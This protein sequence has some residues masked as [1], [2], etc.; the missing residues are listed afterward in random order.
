MKTNEFRVKEVSELKSHLSNLRRE[1]FKIKLVK[2]SG[3]LVKTHQFRE[4]RRDIARIETILRE[5]EGSS[6]E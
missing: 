4:I 1:Q 3:E 5:K 6:N 2:A